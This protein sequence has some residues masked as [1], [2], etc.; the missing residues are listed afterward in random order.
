MNRK[1]AR[2]AKGACFFGCAG[3]P[4]AKS[5]AVL[6]PQYHLLELRGRRDY[7]VGCLAAEKRRARAV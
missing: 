1:G 7:T 5:R 3:K 4:K 6:T 2:G